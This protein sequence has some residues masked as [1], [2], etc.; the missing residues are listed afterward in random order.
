MSEVND[1]SP[2][3]VALLIVD[4]QESFMSVIDS[5]DKLLQRCCFAT[6]SARLLGMPIVFTEQVPDKL[7]PRHPRL[8]KLAPNATVFPKT[9]FSCFKADNFKKYLQD[10][11][12]E[13]LLIGGLETPICIYQTVIEALEQD[14]D[15]TLLT[16]CI[17]C[18][19]PEDGESILKFLNEETCHKVPSE[20]VFYSILG[21]A[22]HP[23][24]RLFSA[25]VKKYP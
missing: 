23:Q 21:D 12:I 24:F 17:G 25:L 10:Q 22:N 1:H 9:A 4:I 18:R 20:T 7:G 19:R 8:A 6:E 13:H 11:E 15:V 16:D 14:F 3:G 2:K 5:A